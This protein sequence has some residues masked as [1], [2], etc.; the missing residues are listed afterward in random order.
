MDHLSKLR[1]IAICALLAFIQ[2]CADMQINNGVEAFNRGDYDRAAAHW[3]KLAENGNYL[4]QYNVGLLWE[5]GLGSTP[6]NLDMAVNWFTLSGNQGFT[7]AMVRMANLQ[8]NNGDET[9]AVGWYALAAR[10][11]NKD[12]ITALTK[13]GQIVPEPDLLE[14]QQ[15]QKQQE[16]A[17]ASEGLVALLY[18]MSCS[19]GACPNAP[20]PA[21][22][23][24][25]Y[26]NT[27]KNLEIKRDTAELERD[28]K[29]A[30]K[31]LDESMYE[32]DKAIN[33]QDLFP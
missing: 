4:A 32:L 22:S 29:K 6:K 28:T 25:S 14:Q 11:G 10:F 26:S 2:G 33:Q 5:G 16:D 1:I 18:L 31:D 17:D 3:N 20:A 15:L 30:L 13:I 19:Q 21:Q 8:I 24:A 27:N 23:P 7:P 12:A 9:Q